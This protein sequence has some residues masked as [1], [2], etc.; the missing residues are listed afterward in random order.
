LESACGR[1]VGDQLKN[2]IVFDVVDEDLHSDLSKSKP[3]KK[4][5][6]DGLS[7]PERRAAIHL[8]LISRSVEPTQQDLSLQKMV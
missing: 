8:D 2:R 6:D 3:K 5:I 7:T 1:G 4:S